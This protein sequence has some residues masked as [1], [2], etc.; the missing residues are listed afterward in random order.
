M[1]G[2]ELDTVLIDRQ[3]ADLAELNEAIPPDVDFE[4]V[5]AI[6]RAW[7]EMHGGVLPAARLSTEKRP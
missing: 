4:R 6:H 7:Y 5:A 1:S 3:Y 2:E